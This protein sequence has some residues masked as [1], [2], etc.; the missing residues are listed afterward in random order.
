[1]RDRLLGGSAAIRLGDAEECGHLLIEEPIARLIRLHPF[2]VDD[3]LRDGAFSGVGDDFLRRTG[4]GFDIDFGMRN[5]VALE[6]AFGFA[7][8]RT[9]GRRVHDQ[10]HISM[11]NGRMKLGGGTFCRKQRCLSVWV[12]TLGGRDCE[13]RFGMPDDWFDGSDEEDPNEDADHLHR[14]QNDERP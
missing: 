5:V 8:V 3:E 10:S 12:L 13:L 1:M 11:I 6:K 9:P 2:A 7:A 4:R 14:R